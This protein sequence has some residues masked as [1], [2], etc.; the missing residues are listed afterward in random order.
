MIKQLIVI[1]ALLCFCLAAQAQQ[2][3]SGQS[4]QTSGATTSSA[5][6]DKSQKKAVIKPTMADYCRKHTC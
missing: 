6:S 2:G 1:A 5:T 3:G 4:G